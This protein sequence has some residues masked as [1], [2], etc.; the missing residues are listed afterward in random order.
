MARCRVCG[1]R[2]APSSEPRERVQNVIGPIATPNPEPIQ[3]GV[4]F[5]PEERAYA[6]P[7]NLM[8]LNDYGTFSL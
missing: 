1:S 5:D 2:R 8:D 7:T 6:E 4:F 3:P